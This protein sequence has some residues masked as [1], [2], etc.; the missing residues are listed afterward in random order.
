MTTEIT[1]VSAPHLILPFDVHNMLTL[2]VASVTSEISGLGE[3]TYNSKANEFVVERLHLI[4]QESSSAETELKPEALQGFL[5]SYLEGKGDPIKLRFHWHSHANMSLF[6]SA[7]DDKLCQGW[8]APWFLALVT[9]KKG[10]YLARLELREPFPLTL[11]V[12]VMLESYYDPALATSI[13]AEVKEKVKEKVYI[14]EPYQPKS[15]DFKDGC[16]VPNSTVAGTGPTQ[17]REYSNATQEAEFEELIKDFKEK[18]GRGPSKKQR[19]EMRERILNTPHWNSG[20]STIPG[21]E[22]VAAMEHEFMAGKGPDY[23]QDNGWY[24]V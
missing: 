18:H 21:D 5:M 13:A 14:K 2:Y 24:G 1:A 7:Q 23:E 3:V 10:E 19:R 16:W 8:N 17:A 4:E 9:N 11:P 20:D 15:W 12:V 22:W 6:W